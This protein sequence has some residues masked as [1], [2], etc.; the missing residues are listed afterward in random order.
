[1]LAGTGAEAHPRVHA[2]T[3]RVTHCYDAVALDGDAPGGV[4]EHVPAMCFQVNDAL[5]G[6]VFGGLAYAGRRM[7]FYAFSVE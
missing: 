5:H 7:R 6:D 1:M 4:E 3:L 2:G